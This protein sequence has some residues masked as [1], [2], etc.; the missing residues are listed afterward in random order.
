MQAQSPAQLHPKARDTAQACGDE[1]HDHDHELAITAAIT[2]FLSAKL[3]APLAAHDHTDSK[4]TRAPGDWDIHLSK[5]LRL[6]H[7]KY[8]PG[9][10]NYLR[11][12][13]SDRLA[14]FKT[15]KTAG[16]LKLAEFPTRLRRQGVHRLLKQSHFI[17][18]EIDL[19]RFYERS[20]AAFCSAVAATLEFGAPTWT[21]GL[22]EWSLGPSGHTS[23]KGVGDGY[24]RFSPACADDSGDAVR[25]TFNSLESVRELFPDLAIWEFKNLNFADANFFSKIMKY[26]NR[27][28]FPWVD[29][30]T[31]FPGISC[32]LDH[33]SNSDVKKHDGPWITR[34]KMG[35][36]SVFP[37][38]DLDATSWA[39]AT[40]ADAT[41][42]SINAGLF[43]L[44]GLRHRQEQTLYLSDIIRPSSDAN[45]YELETGLFLAIM[46]DAMRRTELLKTRI[47][48]TWTYR[49]DG[50]PENP[51][52]ALSAPSAIP[53]L[54]G[55][56]KKLLAKEQRSLQH[57]IV[58]NVFCQCGLQF[59]ATKAVQEACQGLPFLH[60]R[61]YRRQKVDLDGTISDIPHCNPRA[62]ITVLV[63]KDGVWFGGKPYLCEAKILVNGHSYNPEA[64]KRA[65]S[66]AV[67]LERL[68]STVV[69]KG[70]VA[71]RSGDSPNNSQLR[72]EARAYAAFQAAGIRSVATFV[73]FF[74]TKVDKDRKVPA[75]NLLVLSNVG[76]PVSVQRLKD[77]HRRTFME[78]L[79]S[80]HKAGWLHGSLSR[81]KLLKNKEVFALSIVGFGKARQQS[82][83]P[84][85]AKR[86]RDKETELLRKILS[87][88]DSEAT[89]TSTT[90]TKPVAGPS[91]SS[92]G[93]APTNA[94]KRDRR[95]PSPQS[96][97]GGQSKKRVKQ[98]IQ[99]K[100]L[101]P[102][103]SKR[104]S[105][106]PKSGR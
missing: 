101:G 37:G 2:E 100:S 39:Q 66:A 61:Q 58:K 62:Q 19:S 41:F 74:R 82:A 89:S 36:D 25:A 1:N 106:S 13:T 67:L 17:R 46:Q 21:S 90:R 24:M 83:N 105:A 79:A 4:S 27:T 32:N 94:R 102:V 48:D 14:A 16:D 98:E 99:G 95:S 28:D 7:V 3:V 6:K 60:S 8:L 103:R 34:A 97:K 54:F 11:A 30:S 93:A 53:L 18:R 55:T 87:G 52:Q 33:P 51:K 38:L 70:E 45:Y 40:K 22:V 72:Q 57:D 29:C 104:R 59:K 23:N 92:T 12:L 88:S 75:A 49:E 71:S 78:I 50:L 56:S 85:E 80:I 5:D 44:I 35:N 31:M 15:G 10:N 86:E 91:R 47:P 68:S 42:L 77:F 81:S 76:D 84:T 9:L 64:G 43:E 20:S 65:D 26:A 69:L 96:S 73:G 63:N